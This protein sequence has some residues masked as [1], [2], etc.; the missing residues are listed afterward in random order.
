[1][2]G[3][4]E[5]ARHHTHHGYWQ[6]GVRGDGGPATQGT[7]NGPKGIVVDAKEE[8]RLRDRHR[9]SGTAPHP[10]ALGAAQF[11]GRLWPLGPRVEWRGGSGSKS[12]VWP[13]PR[14]LHRSLR[15]G[16]HRRHLEPTAC[17]A[18]NGYRGKARSV[19]KGATLYLLTDFVARHSELLPVKAV[20]A[21]RNVTTKIRAMYF[22]RS[23]NHL[24]FDVCRRG[25]PQQ[26][27]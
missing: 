11:A 17:A 3:G 10:P 23:Q 12:E 8:N 26:L 20:H 1:M 19:G 21:Q 6:E 27:Q 18:C 25:F 7:F 5:H 9:E 13:T 2:E 22:D 16:L 14:H 4:P 15:G 24:V